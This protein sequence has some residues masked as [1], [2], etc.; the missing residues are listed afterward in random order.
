ML[1]LLNRGSWETLDRQERLER[2]GNPYVPSSFY[3]NTAT[4]LVKKL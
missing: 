3:S 1:S 4:L 2:R